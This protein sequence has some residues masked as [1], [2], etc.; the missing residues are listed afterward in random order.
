MRH[1]V[2]THRRCLPSLVHLACSRR[3]SPLKTRRSCVRQR[4]WYVCYASFEAGPEKKTAR[5]D[6]TEDLAFASSRRFYRI[7]FAPQSEALLPSLRPAAGAAGQESCSRFKVKTA[8]RVPEFS[9]LPFSPEAG[10][11]GARKLAMAVKKTSALLAAVL[12]YCV[13]AQVPD[14]GREKQPKNSFLP[15]LTAIAG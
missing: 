6:Q 4:Y 11:D 2:R 8:T 10:S 9:R 7:L 13:A 3:P 5:M 12:G 1:R 15:Q 14:G